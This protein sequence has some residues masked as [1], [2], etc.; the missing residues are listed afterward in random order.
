[1]VKVPHHQKNSDGNRRELS[2]V[3]Q[4]VIITFFVIYGAIS[5]VSLPVCRPCVEFP[6]YEGLPSAALQTRYKGEPLTIWSARGP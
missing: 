3:E 1:M 2:T 5:T 6:H 4:G